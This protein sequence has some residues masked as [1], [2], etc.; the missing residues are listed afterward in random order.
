MIEFSNQDH[1]AIR[2]MEDGVEKLVA[3]DDERFA[4]LAV[5]AAPF[6]I[7]LPAED[8]YRHAIQSLVDSHAQ[9]RRYDNGNS[10]A[11]YVTSSNP[12]WA[13]EAQAFVVW[14]DAVWAY[15]YAELDKVLSGERAQPNVEAFINELPAIAWPEAE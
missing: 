12:D 5:E 13:A 7:S 4:D 1:T 11:T 9:S 10:L 2:F 3:S 15:A 8:D 14:R 6:P